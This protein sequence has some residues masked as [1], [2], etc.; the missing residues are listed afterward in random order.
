MPLARIFTRN[1]ERTVDLSRQLQQQGY[2][3][4]V[5]S[6]DQSHLAP[7]DLEIEFEM[8]ERADVLERAADLASEFEADIA[9]APGILQSAPETIVELK[10]QSPVHPIEAQPAPVQPAPVQP[11]PVQPAPV[12]PAA[13]TVV[14]IAPRKELPSDQEREFE[15]AFSSA[16]APDIRDTPEVIEIPVMEQAPLPPV[17]F[18]ED[19][20][21]VEPVLEPVRMAE[22]P[23]VAVPVHFSGPVAEPA[24][25]ADPAQY[26]GHLTPFS[27]LPPRPET[28]QA[29]AETDSDPAHDRYKQILQDGTKMAARTWAGVLA[30]TSSTS[31]SLGDHF[32]EY[33]KR[34]QIRATEARAAHTARLLDLEQRRAEAHERAMELE[35]ARVAA[36]ARL[37]ELLQQRS[38]GL[39][40]ERIPSEPEHG[41]WQP[42]TYTHTVPKQTVPTPT[43]S[44]YTV[45]KEDVSRKVPPV[46]AA[47]T[48]QTPPAPPVAKPARTALKV[49][50]I[51]LWQKVNPPLRAVLTGGAA[52]SA[53]FVMGIALGIFH[54]RAPLASPANHDS[55]GV[56]VQ[57][58]APAP[59]LAKPQ[60]VPASQPATQATMQSP[61]K[62]SPRQRSQQ[63][64]AEQ[65][66]SNIGDDVVIRHFSR[67]LPTQKPKQSGQQAGLKHFSDLDN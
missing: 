36:S 67:P 1:A 11:A 55:N 16:S 50:P 48:R 33:K 63:L 2:K 9:V 44:K 49:T 42:S 7:A 17:A 43:V 41:L 46:A 8:C 6:P 51:A 61:D 28:P 20:P 21:Q 24:K 56:T 10:A 39:P 62:P 15:A 4:E 31:A 58:S 66:E 64:V 38:P 30:I 14:K 29:S 52:V 37:E 34:A 45:P 27:S 5:V 12:Q 23:S 40:V 59:A 60:P 18:L 32:R 35:A 25:S 13:D 22:K 3:V 47:S 19:F 54:S 57:S 26:L 53:L 65:S